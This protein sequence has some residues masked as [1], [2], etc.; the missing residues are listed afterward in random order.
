MPYWP[1]D[2][3]P[4]TPE[5]MPAAGS[6]PAPAPYAGPGFA[7]APDMLAPRDMTVSYPADG[8]LAGVSGNAVQETPM[9]APDVMPLYAGAVK[10]IYTGGAGDPAGRDDMAM[11]VAG[12]V[13]AA[14]APYVDHMQDTYAA[15]S[16]IRDLLSFA[17][18]T[19]TGAHLD[20]GIAP[21]VTEPGGGFYEP[22]R[23]YGGGG[24]DLRSTPRVRAA[25]GSDPRA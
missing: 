25:P 17:P 24:R 2:T 12:A 7:I 8:V 6:G 14:E 15:G 11:T 19:A 16:Q 10:E 23:D 21:G 13:H 9:V 22:P 4:V 5:Q 3:P 18:V 20:P 1:P